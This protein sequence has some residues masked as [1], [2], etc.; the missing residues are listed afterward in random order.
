MHIKSTHTSYV[1]IDLTYTHIILIWL[2]CNHIT[3]T[4]RST[5]LN[6]QQRLILIIIYA[7]TR[8]N[9]TQQQQYQHN[10]LATHT[11]SIPQ[12]TQQQHRNHTHQTQHA[13]L[14][15]TLCI[16]HTD[17]NV[18]YMSICARYIRIIHVLTQQ[19]IHSTHNNYISSYT[20]Q[21]IHINSIKTIY[22][23]IYQCN[24]VKY[25]TLTHTRVCL[26][27]Y[28]ITTTE[29][30]NYTHTSVSHHTWALHIYDYIKAHTH[31]TI[32]MCSNTPHTTV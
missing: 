5:S 23:Y 14:A 3:H 4:H 28:N 17:V 11:H 8:H 10:T 21:C 32:Y 31:N 24:I 6:T 19:F 22:K 2:V 20:Q 13:K 1:H 9:N 25:T 18:Y 15:C 7:T 29:H 12:F 16:M 27:R 30:V 26:W